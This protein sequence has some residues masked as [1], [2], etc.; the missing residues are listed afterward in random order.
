MFLFRERTLEDTVCMVFVTVVGLFFNCLRKGLE[1]WLRSKKKEKSG[2]KKWKSTY[3]F[4]NRP[5]LE[6]STHMAAHI[7]L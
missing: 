2:K 4:S 5:E 1:E 7:H 3:C 6:P